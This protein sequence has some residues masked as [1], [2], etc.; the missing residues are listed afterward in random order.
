MNETVSYE[1]QIF[2][3]AVA[4]DCG[5]ARE[6][7]LQHACDNDRDLRLRVE[8]MI[9]LHGYQDSVLDKTSRSSFA[10]AET[11]DPITTG[12]IIDSYK[13]LQQ[14]GAGG[15]GVVFMAQQEKPVRRKVAIKVI[16]HGMDSKNV[17]ARFEAER[18]ALAIMN[19]PN[20]S[21]IYDAGVTE[22]GRP[23]FVMELITGLPITR[24]CDKRKLTLRK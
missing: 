11:R 22:S 18:Q 13:L 2:L 4:I 1:E 15:M 17:I 3:E 16:R 5:E 20:I 24:F 9:A 14:I 10:Q 19:H 7:F 23:Y 12:T 21:R 6:A 8:G